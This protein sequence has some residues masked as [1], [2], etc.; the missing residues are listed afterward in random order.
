M[1]AG[2]SLPLDG[3]AAFAESACR[4]TLDACSTLRCWQATVLS[5]GALDAGEFDRRSAELPCATAARGG[6]GFL[7]RCSTGNSM[8]L[9]HRAGGRAAPE[10]VVARPW[11]P[12]PVDAIH[13]GGWTGTRPPARVHL[14]YRLA[15]DDYRGGDAIQLIVEH[16]APPETA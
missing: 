6:R 2:L 4:S 7:S 9:G 5:D 10:T 16:C 14:A 13:F 15:V 1:A 11:R 12:T 8:S 3:L